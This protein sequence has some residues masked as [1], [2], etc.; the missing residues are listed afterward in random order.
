MEVEVRVLRVL[1]VVRVA[2][3]AADAA[4]HVLFPEFRNNSRPLV[5]WLKIRVVAVAA[6]AVAVAVA[7]LVVD[8]LAAL[9]VVRLAR[10]C[11]LAPTPWP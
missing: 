6:V 7:V 11:S 4:V 9:A 10:T 2:P 3:P 1:R 8:S 5:T